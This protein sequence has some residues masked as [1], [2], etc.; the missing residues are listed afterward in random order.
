M[1]KRNVRKTEVTEKV[2]TTRTQ[3]RKAA[4]PVVE[5]EEVAVVEEKGMTL[6]DA[7]AIVTSLALIT[8][9][10]LLDAANGEYGKGLFF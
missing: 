5:V 4:A 3:S 10:I 2:R 7:I 1:A 6:D 8:A 9:I